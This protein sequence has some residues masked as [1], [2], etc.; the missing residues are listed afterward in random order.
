MTALGDGP[1]LLYD[2]GSPVPGPGGIPVTYEQFA[3]GSLPVVGAGVEALPVPRLSSGLK[4]HG[5]YQGSGFTEPKYIARRGDGQS[6]SCHG[7]CT[8]SPPRSTA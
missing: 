3:T 5:E 1:A 2:T 8:W 7:C 6:C 4:L